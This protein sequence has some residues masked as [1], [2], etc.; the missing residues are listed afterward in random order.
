MGPKYN[1]KEKQK[2]TSA[3]SP[4]QGYQG[5]NLREY[6]PVF[7]H[8]ENEDYC[9]ISNFYRTAFSTPHPMKWLFEQ[10]KAISSTS[11][12]SNNRPRDKG[13]G[14]I[15]FRYSEQYHIYCKAIYFSN[16]NTARKIISAGST[17][18]YKAASCSI[19]GFSDKAWEEYNLKV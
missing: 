4:A 13:P 19:K 12:S 2:A 3:L 17:T 1:K 10:S 16:Q 8:N 7:F 6:G 15:A 11:A 18:E 5:A 9:F 14:T